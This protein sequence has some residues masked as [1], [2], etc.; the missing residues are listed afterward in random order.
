MNAAMIA[1]PLA[2]VHKSAELRLGGLAEL[3]EGA[4]RPGPLD[5]NILEMLCNP[6]I[7]NNDPDDGHKPPKRTEKSRSLLTAEQEVELALAIRQG[8]KEARTRMIVANRGLVV[9]I[10]RNFVGRGLPLE[11]L[12]GEG[13]LGLIR[14]TQD[15]DPA[16]GLR[17]SIYASYWIRQAI[18][19]SLVRTANSIRL[20]HHMFGMVSRWRRTE[21]ELQQKS[22]AVPTPE[23]VSREMGLADR[24]YS[25]VQRALRA[26]HFVPG[27]SEELHKLDCEADWR[28]APDDR[29]ATEEDLLFLKRMLDGLYEW[30]R[31]VLTLRFGLG[32][33]QPLTHRELG[34][35][36][37]C[38][39]EWA[40]KL[41]S[42]M[43]Q[44]LERRASGARSL[45]SC[46]GDQ[47]IL[48]RH[49]DTE[50][51]VRQDGIPEPRRWSS[52]NPRPSLPDRV[53]ST[54]H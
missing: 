2:K 34:L 12:V 36:L 25:L 29:M 17:F 22:G 3:A 46:S 5:R 32:A 40:S 18:R 33:G 20:P 53:Q 14:A 9:A 8:D 31:E 41:V 51:G 48:S 27:G 38:S 19:D 35:R 7:H 44:K 47:T 54:A 43:L 10:A 45:A 16:Y 50:P 49:G 13:N 23:Q 4:F 52:R 6:V 1:A 26:L 39:P 42:R 30:E 28:T 37:G 15:F 24:Q 11:D 21:R